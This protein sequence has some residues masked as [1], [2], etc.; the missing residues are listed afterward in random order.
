MIKLSQPK[1]YGEIKPLH[2]STGRP[3]RCASS[4]IVIPK[5]ED[6]P[7]CADCQARSCQVGACDWVEESQP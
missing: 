2:G 5:A 7:N 3:I 4:H 1:A 6:H